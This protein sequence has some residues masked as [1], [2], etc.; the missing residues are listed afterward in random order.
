MPSRLSAF[1]ITFGIAA[2]MT[3]VLVTGR[4]LLIPFAIA[5]LIWYVIT[6]LSRLIGGYTGVPGWLALTSSIVFFLIILGL[7]VELISGNIASVRDAAPM[8]QTNLERLIDG[9]TR[10][11]GMTERPTIAHV[12]DQIDVKALISGVATAVAKVA[13][14]AGLIVVYVIF[15]LAEQRTFSRKIEALFPGAERREE[16][17]LILSEIQKRTQTYIAVKTL[18]SLLTA[19]IS[20][21]VL[22]AVGLDLAGFWAFVIFLLAYIPT[23]GS[24]L[25]VIFPAL[26]AL[27]QF[28]GG[29]EFLIIAV[30]LGAAQII[31]GNVLEPRMMGKSLNLS[32]LVVIVSLAIWGSIW[33]VTGMFLSVP[34]TVILMIILAEFKQ[35]RPIAILLSADGRV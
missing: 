31:I 28:G 30:G 17:Q 14:N 23:I 33:G 19:V 13:G 25:G 27:L 22:V 35:T 12:I 6:A 20:Y 7:I 4:E 10:F 3:Y 9:I 24:L 18:L 1:G 15:L 8:Y 5:V 34:I 16:V 11:G 26:M 21:I 2:L 29:S 32:S